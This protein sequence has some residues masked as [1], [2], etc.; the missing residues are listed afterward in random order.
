MAKAKPTSLLDDVLARAANSKPGFRPW[1][2]RLPKDAQDEL[3]EVRQ[4]FDRTRHQYRAYALA[5]IEA[6]KERGWQV[7]GEQQVI[8]WLRLKG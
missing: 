1:F 5:I 8:A 2:E 3:N 7:A 6:A 4:R